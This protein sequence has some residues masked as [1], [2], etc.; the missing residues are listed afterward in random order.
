MADVKDAARADVAD[1]ADVTEVKGVKGVVGAATASAS[2]VRVA[3]TGTARAPMVRALRACSARSVSGLAAFATGKPAAGCC[4]T[5][6]GNF[7]VA[8]TGSV[9]VDGSARDVGDV[10]AVAGSGPAASAT[11]GVTSAAR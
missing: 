1:V 6:T 7:S 4:E 11:A 5:A 10:G 9:S 8:N 3:A 2:D